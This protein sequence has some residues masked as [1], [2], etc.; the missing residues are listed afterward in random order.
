VTIFLFDFS[1]EM[2]DAI[3]Q[4]RKCCFVSDIHYMGH[5]F[6]VSNRVYRVVSCKTL[7]YR[8]VKGDTFLA[9]SSGYRYTCDFDNVINP[10]GLIKPLTR[11]NLNFFSYVTSIVGENGCH[12]CPC[13]E[14]LNEEKTRFKC[15]ILT[16]RMTEDNIIG[17]PGM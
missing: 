4:G 17:C 2:N 7:H 15:G 1:S 6:I 16:V 3:L 14:Y 5:L 9:N 10:L 13:I 12:M 11:L 8:R